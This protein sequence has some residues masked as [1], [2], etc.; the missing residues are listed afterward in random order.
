MLGTV[1]IRVAPYRLSAITAM[2][3]ISDLNDPNLASFSFWQLVQPFFELLQHAT[4]GRPDRAAR[5]LQ[6]AKRSPRP[7]SETDDL[8]YV[9]VDGHEGAKSSDFVC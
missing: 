2:L 3:V 6:S 1:P 4:E 7:A 5:R 9:Q 8:G